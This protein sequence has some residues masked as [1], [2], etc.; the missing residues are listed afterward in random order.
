[1]I[2]TL[3]TGIVLV[4]MGIYCVV[5]KSNLIKKVIGLAVFTNSIHLIL[6]TIGYKE[7]GISPI[8]TPANIMFFASAS[9][10]PLP[11]AF[12]LTSIV[13]QLSIT[14]LA[15]SISI[16]AFRHLGTHNTDKMNKLSG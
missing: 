1:M 10:D 14:A 12:V 7:S 5:M 8:M 2:E 11:Q 9:V 4:I 13:I 15:L 3:I 6:I 16:I